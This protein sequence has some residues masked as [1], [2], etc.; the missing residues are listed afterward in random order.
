MTTTL[1]SE[2]ALVTEG[3]RGLGAAIAIAEIFCCYRSRCFQLAYNLDDGS[4]WHELIG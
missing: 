3:S 2:V 4:C 1:V